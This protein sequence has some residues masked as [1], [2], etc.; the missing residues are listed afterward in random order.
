M[1]REK[2]KTFEI[3]QSIE[4]I[5]AMT[6]T[7]SLTKLLVARWANADQKLCHQGLNLRV[8]SSPIQFL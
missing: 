7:G 3:D 6:K 4:V 5:S 8:C 1:F 2:V